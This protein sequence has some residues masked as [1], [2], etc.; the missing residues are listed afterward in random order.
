M[1]ICWVVD[2]GLVVLLQGVLKVVEQ[3]P[4]VSPG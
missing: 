3:G 4:V 2:H 1:W